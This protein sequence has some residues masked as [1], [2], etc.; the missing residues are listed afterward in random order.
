MDESEV[1]LKRNLQLKWIIK[2]DFLLMP[3]QPIFAMYSPMPV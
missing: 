3:Q 2:S 1:I